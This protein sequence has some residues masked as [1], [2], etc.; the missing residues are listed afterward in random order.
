LRILL[1]KIEIE[2]S[3]FDFFINSAKKKRF[4]EIKNRVDKIIVG[5]TKP[6]EN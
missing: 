1:A 2:G 6:Q 5:E 3:F 4:R